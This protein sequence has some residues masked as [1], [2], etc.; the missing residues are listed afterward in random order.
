MSLNKRAWKKREE[1]IGIDDPLPSSPHGACSRPAP[2]A[3]SA[4]LRKGNQLRSQGCTCAFA[5]CRRKRHQ[6]RERDAWLR[7]RRCL[8]RRP[9]RLRPWEEPPLIANRKESVSS[10]FLWPRS[11]TR[12]PR[13]RLLS[14]HLAYCSPAPGP[15]QFLAPQGSA[16]HG[17]GKLTAKRLSDHVAEA[18]PPA[19]DRPSAAPQTRERP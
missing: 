16:W 8:P 14:R 13:K 19:A 3:R 10:S 5:R 15:V 11:C 18:C 6:T 2:S 9:H 1:G 17:R 12:R 7:P 4:G